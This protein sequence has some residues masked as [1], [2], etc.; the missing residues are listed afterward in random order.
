M[1]FPWW[2]APRN[3]FN[4]ARAEIVTS[5]E[6]LVERLSKTKSVHYLCWAFFALL[7]LPNRQPSHMNHVPYSDW[8]AHR[9]P[10]DS[11]SQSCCKIPGCLLFKHM[12]KRIEQRAGSPQQPTRHAICSIAFSTV[13]V[14]HVV[15]R[16]S[17]SDRVLRLS[18]HTL[19]A[20][21]TILRRDNEQPCDFAAVISTRTSNSCGPIRRDHISQVP[22]ALKPRHPSRLGPCLLSWHMH[23]SSF[24]LGR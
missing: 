7:Q 8:L 17:C 19:Q 3:K 5:L 16:M 9:G 2:T 23:G 21:A 18:V 20:A 13:F 10:W 22:E 4:I 15:R 1:V 24:S 11:H 12:F 6:I 14:H